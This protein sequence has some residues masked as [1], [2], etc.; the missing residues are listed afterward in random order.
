MLT[1][2]SVSEPE[3]YVDNNKIKMANIIEN[4][5]IIAVMFKDRFG[6]RIRLTSNYMDY[7]SISNEGLYDLYS[8]QIKNSNSID[9]L[10]IKTLFELFKK[11]YHSK[12]TD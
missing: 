8:N 10:R 1:V 6:Y 4:S 7:I 9:Y 5:K 3:F 11:K 12:E 2:E